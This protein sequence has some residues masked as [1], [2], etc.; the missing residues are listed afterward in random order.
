MNVMT[1]ERI[2]LRNQAGF[3]LLIGLWVILAPAVADA[4]AIV[5]TLLEKNTDKEFV[6]FQ[7]TGPVKHKKVFIL[8]NPDRVVVDLESVSG[9][10]VG[11][12]PPNGTSLVRAIRFGQFDAQT[13]RLVIDLAGPVKTASLHQFSATGNQPHR[14]VIE[15]EPRAQGSGTVQGMVQEQRKHYPAA[16][17]PPAAKLPSKPIIVIDA[18]HGGKD[19]GAR[20]VKGSWEKDIT[21]AYAL[22]LRKELLR[23]GRYDVVLTRET[24]MFILLHERVKIAQRAKGAAFIS[25]HADSAPGGSKARGLSI[26]TLSENASD[27]ESAALAAQENQADIID[28]LDLGAAVDKDV[29]NILIDL[30]QRETKN[31]SARLAD[32]MVARFSEQGIRLLPNTHRYAG[33]RVLKAP[34]VPSVLV[35][36]GFLSHPEEEQL[37]KSD[38]YRQKVIKGIIYGLDALFK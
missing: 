31:K 5:R 4:Q 8:P 15:L 6:V 11:M 30:A 36:A 34:D 22:A 13:S 29:A 26:Y 20:G 28:G 38:A 18:G 21:L 16:P 25:L 2:G 33:F 12:P 32:L 19:P 3:L 14:I 1:I 10:G 17:P 35:E 27:E 23:T 9:S 24:D 37:V 7:T